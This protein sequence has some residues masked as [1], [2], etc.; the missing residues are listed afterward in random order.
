MPAVPGQGKAA[1]E[2]PELS[3]VPEV[4]NTG[5]ASIDSKQKA[6]QLFSIPARLTKDADERAQAADKPTAE[7]PRRK[8]K[9]EGSLPP[10]LKP[11]AGKQ[12]GPGQPAPV[13]SQSPTPEALPQAS[14]A[15]APHPDP[16]S[17][18]PQ[19]A[20]PLG[21]ALAPA[22]DPKAPQQMIDSSL[23][24]PGSQPALSMP[25]G[26]AAAAPGSVAAVAPSPPVQTI[27]EASPV[28]PYF[29]A[30]GSLIAP[31]PEDSFW[32]SVPAAGIEDSQRRKET[33]EAGQDTQQHDAATDAFFS[34]SAGDAADT[35]FWASAG[36]HA[37]TAMQQ[38]E[39]SSVH[40]AEQEGGS[41]ETWNDEQQRQPLQHSIVP[42]S[43]TVSEPGGNSVVSHIV[44]A[45]DMTDASF[46]GSSTLTHH[47]PGPLPGL[48]TMHVP[49]SGQHAEPEPASSSNPVARKGE[50]NTA[51]PQAA[52]E[53]QASVIAPS[54][55]P[56]GL[57]GDSYSSP[58]DQYAGAFTSGQDEDT[59]FFEGLGAPGNA[60]TVT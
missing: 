35:D 38:P 43:H 42:D 14:D 5:F 24:R 7:A 28:K 58:L 60:T 31:A 6:S 16:P 3:P 40:L 33:L 18:T 47:Q 32:Q 50:D 56:F 46:Q 48:S 21:S 36:Q 12:Q 53:Q 20:L 22:K 54:S 9:E 25:A 52:Q 4:I 27:P 13:S 49:S 23:L 11:P 2:Q 51:P 8:K 17:S 44:D 10:R 34:A 39:L 30:F 57:A 29:P 59:S 45:A 41:K 37:E 19:R 26:D 1:R 55:N 15:L